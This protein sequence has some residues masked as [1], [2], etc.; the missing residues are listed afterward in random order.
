MGWSGCTSPAYGCSPMLPTR[1]ATAHHRATGG[2]PLK[3]TGSSMERSTNNV[4]AGR[5][6]PLLLSVAIIGLVCTFE[7][8]NVAIGAEGKPKQCRKG[9]T[10]NVGQ[11][12][13]A[14]RRGP[15]MHIL[16]GGIEF[17]VGEDACVRFRRDG[18]VQQFELK[19][20]ASDIH[21]D[22][23]RLEVLDLTCGRLRPVTVKTSWM[24][25]S[26]VVAEVGKG[27][28]VSRFKNHHR[29]RIETEPRLEGG[30]PAG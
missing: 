20:S 17:R 7:A 23:G 11:S 13:L 27:R 1:V 9:M 28:M 16:S 2:S 18:K 5:Q 8:G 4:A 25:D 19:V 6:T 21:N 10:L 14:G 26:V 24:W 12:C 15:M 3:I 30:A 29:L 22:R